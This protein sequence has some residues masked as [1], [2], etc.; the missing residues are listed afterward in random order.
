M[1]TQHGDLFR[2]RFDTEDV[3]QSA[4]LS[5]WSEIEAFE[6]RGE[7]SFRRWLARLVTNKLRDLKDFHQAQRRGVRD[8]ERTPESVDAT[9]ELRG[10]D[11]LPSAEAGPAE[12]AGDLEL[13]GA[14]L[15]A[16]STLSEDE[17]EILCMRQFEH[18]AWSEI[19]NTLGISQSAARR[20]WEA[21]LVRLTGAMN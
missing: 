13:H 2:Q 10:L 9:G 6:Y 12:Q 16:M 11:A 8:E 5:A 1:R 14:L 20:R 19:A 17:Q 7:G 4:F 3:L 15:E 21:A 18:L